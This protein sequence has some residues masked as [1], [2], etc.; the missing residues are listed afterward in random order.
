M[1]D[2]PQRDQSGPL[3]AVF[4]CRNGREGRTEAGASFE[5]QDTVLLGAKTFL[6]QGSTGKTPSDSTGH[7][8]PDGLEQLLRYAQSINALC[9]FWCHFC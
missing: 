7:C 1:Q 2:Q 8:R 4:G 6:S 9:D 5:I 3:R